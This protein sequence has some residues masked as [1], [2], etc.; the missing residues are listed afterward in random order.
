MRNP[1]AHHICDAP[2]LCVSCRCANTNITHRKSQRKKNIVPRITSSLADEDDYAADFD[3]VASD[4]SNFLLHAS[5]L[6]F[7]ATSFRS[8]FSARKLCDSLPD[9]LRSHMVM[10][11][12]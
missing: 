9:R 6:H 11:H 8:A 4:L 7:K 2:V 12:T 1:R 5:F 10:M 3:C